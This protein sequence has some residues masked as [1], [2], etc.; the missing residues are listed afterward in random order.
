MRPRIAVLLSFAAAAQCAD[1]FAIID[2]RDILVISG[3]FMPH[4]AID[5][6]RKAVVARFDSLPLFAFARS[7]DSST[8][9][10]GGFVSGHAWEIAALD[11]RALRLR[12]RLAL[13]DTVETWSSTGLIFS[14]TSALSPSPDGRWMLVSPVY[15]NGIWG[16]GAVD[17]VTKALGPFMDSLVTA[18]EGITMLRPSSMLPAGGFAVAI[19]GT[20]SRPSRLSGWLMI[21]DGNTLA[22]VD[23][24]KVAPPGALRGA[25]AAANGTVVYVLGTGR[26]FRYDI[27][28]RVLTGPVRLASNSRIALAPKDTSILAVDLGDGF[29]YAGDGLLRIISADLS[30]TRTLSLRG[31]AVD[32][33][34]PTAVAAVASERFPLV[35]VLIG[36]NSVGPL[37]PGQPIR[38]LTVDLRSGAIVQSLPLGS[39]GPG[40]MVLR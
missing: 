34:G 36:N 22:P 5:V 37:F 2:S 30:R 33:Q 17:P 12:W 27:A 16:M 28:S 1:P 35:Y 32:G 29:D 9:F 13:A 19:G 26:L 21:L 39:D 20:W 18:T 3:A 25:I 40:T 4:M 11:V 23:S 10:Y 7:P 6:A 14:S 31:A 15:R 8:V 24:V 38:L